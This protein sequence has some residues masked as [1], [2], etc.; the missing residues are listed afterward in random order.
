MYG[1][2]CGRVAR[3]VTCP[4]RHSPRKIAPYV[5]ETLERTFER[6]ITTPANPAVSRRDAGISPISSRLRALI[7]RVLGASR[8][9][10]DVPQLQ[11]AHEVQGVGLRAKLVVEELVTAV[12]RH[13]R[14]RHARDEVG[15]V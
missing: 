1:S 3:I 9:L 11:L 2:A 6:W 13:Q 15:L 8:S 4:A 10:R 7:A 12:R 14:G 5:R